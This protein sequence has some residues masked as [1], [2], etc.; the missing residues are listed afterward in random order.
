MTMSYRLSDKLQMLIFGDIITH[1]IARDRFPEY[2]ST[3]HAAASRGG[4]IAE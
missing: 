4:Q 1:T 3:L 2:L